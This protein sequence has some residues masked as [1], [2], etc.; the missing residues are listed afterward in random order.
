MM[1]S[2]KI[3]IVTGATGNVGAALLSVLAAGGARLVA[4]DRDEGRVRQH[5]AELPESGAHRAMQVGDL[6]APGAFDAVVAEAID[7]FGRIDGLATTVGAFEMAPIESGGTDL[8]D[9]MLRLNLFTAL[10]AMRTV[11]PSMRATR[12]GSIV[13]IGAGAA[14][15][16]PAQLG[17]YAASKSALLK[18]VES[19]ADELK[20]D[21]IRVN[22]V[23]PG[24]IDTPVNRKAMPDA[25]HARW[26]T[27]TEVANLI[28]FLL[29]DLAS[30]V[31]GTFVAAPGRS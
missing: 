1:L 20:G 6:A 8:W 7:A 29:S 4:V 3:V 16:A 15:K 23:L 10:N 30:G 25:D 28:A 22:A 19:A 14:L 13:A 17:P 2:G 27:P 31:T 24:T 5:L 11:I 26:V 9:R 12:A 21:G 18:L